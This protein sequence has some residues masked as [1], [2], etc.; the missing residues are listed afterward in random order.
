MTHE[1]PKRYGWLVELARLWDTLRSQSLWL[2]ILAGIDKIFRMI[3]G[4]T[5][6]RFSRIEPM[7]LLGGQPAKRVLPQLAL[8]GVTGII[9]LRAEYDYAREIG[10]F[11]LLG[12]R[13]LRY[14]HLPT[15]DNT[16]PSVDDLKRGVAFIDAELEQG[17]SVYIHCW[18][19]LGRAPTMVAAYL[20]A[21]GASP[22]AAWEKIRAWRPFIRPM[23]V[24]MDQLIAFADSLKT[25]P[26][27]SSIEPNAAPVDPQR[28]PLA[29]VKLGEVPIPDTASRNPPSA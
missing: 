22:Q 23:Q 20:V 2:T 29:E 1:S 13:Q 12:A 3:T 9:N 28:V 5:L 11:N 16:A 25:T 10:E 6:V 4:R 18:E 7:I 14:L 26:L 24:Q 21:K 15:A 27:I 8:G 19:G 17:G